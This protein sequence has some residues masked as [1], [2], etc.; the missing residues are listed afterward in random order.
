MAFLLDGNRRREALDVFDFG[1]GHLLDKL[2][3]I[4]RHRFDI[5]AL[6]FGIDRLKGKRRFS[7]T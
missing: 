3:C 7:R 4:R 1:L 5:A 2:A 6:S